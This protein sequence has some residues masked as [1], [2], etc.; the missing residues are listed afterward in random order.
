MSILQGHIDQLTTRVIS[1][2][3]RDTE[4]PQSPVS[5]PIVTDDDPPHC[6]VANRYRADLKE[7]GLGEGL[8]S[9]HYEFPKEL[10]P[11]NAH[12]VCVRHGPDA[13]EVLGS[14]FQLEPARTFDELEPFL[15]HAFATFVSVEDNSRK[16][17]YLSGQSER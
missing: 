5:L 11:M 17:N 7:A 8:H 9:F 4:K 6:V 12:V 10:I 14:P 1:G 13:T 15:S 3:E 2:W 16:L